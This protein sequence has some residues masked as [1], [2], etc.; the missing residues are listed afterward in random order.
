VFCSKMGERD[1]SVPSFQRVFMAG[2]TYSAC[3]SRG[4]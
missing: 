3:N 1:P 4:S 2:R